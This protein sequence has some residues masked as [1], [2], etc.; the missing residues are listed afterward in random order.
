MALDNGALSLAVG[1][2]V[3]VAGTVSTVVGFGLPWVLDY[4]ESDPALGSGPI[5]TIIQDVASLATN[6][7]LASVLTI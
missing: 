4:F 6:F 1:L 7:V 5:C 2:A 3:F